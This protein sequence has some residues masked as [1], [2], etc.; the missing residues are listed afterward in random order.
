MKILHHHKPK[1]KTYL[2]VRFVVYPKRITFEV[3]EQHQRITVPDDGVLPLSD[4]VVSAALPSL[5][6]NY[7]FIRGGWIEGNNH[8]AQIHFTNDT[9]RDRYL[10]WAQQAL[11]DAEPRIIELCEGNK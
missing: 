8:V 9:D 5:N 2:K 7:V 6:E 3:L 10:Q 4:K 1:G 11:I